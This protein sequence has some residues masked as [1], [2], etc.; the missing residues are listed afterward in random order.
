MGLS[1]FDVLNA[2]LGEVY[3]L[4]IDCII[5][6]FKEKNGNQEQGEVWVTSQNATWH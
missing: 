5:H 3:D 4:Y 2:E 6:D 1:P